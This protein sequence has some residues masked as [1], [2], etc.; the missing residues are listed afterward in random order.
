MAMRVKGHWTRKETAS[1]KRARIEKAVATRRRNKAVEKQTLNGKLGSRV[2]K[3]APSPVPASA[4]VAQSQDAIYDPLK[5]AGASPQ[6]TAI[7][8]QS[9]ITKLHQASLDL[10]RDEWREFAQF[11]KD[12]AVNARA[13]LFG[14]LVG[15]GISAEL[16]RG[17]A[18][19]TDLFDLTV[20]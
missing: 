7:R 18:F 9:A 19:D 14:W 4:P 10:Y 6:D 2:K 11:R 12:L 16:A 3:A 1:A 17:L 5:E 15:K 20:I 8:P 13:V